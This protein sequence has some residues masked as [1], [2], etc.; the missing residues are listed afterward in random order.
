LG[1]ELMCDLV[2]PWSPFNHTLIVDYATR[3]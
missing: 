3:S 2:R 1:V